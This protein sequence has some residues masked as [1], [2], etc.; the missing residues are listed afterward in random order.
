M[1][2][3]FAQL[4]RISYS[5]SR[6]SHSIRPTAFFL[7]ARI[8]NQKSI[9]IFSSSFF[10]FLF[11]I[12]MKN[13][14][15]RNVLVSYS[16]STQK[17]SGFCLFHSLIAIA[18][19]FFFTFVAIDP[20]MNKMRKNNKRKYVISHLSLYLLSIYSI[21]LIQCCTKYTVSNWQQTQEKM[22]F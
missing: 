14:I 1:D 21:V 15:I 11:E 16:R 9:W 4:A 5:N 8:N 13:F 2:L 17:H 6:D 18:L 20:T 10:D 12:C 22:K 7:W 3:H 19:I